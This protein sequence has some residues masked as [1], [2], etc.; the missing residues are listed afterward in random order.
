M[1][2]WRMESMGRRR[3]EQMGWRRFQALGWRMGSSI[4]WRFRWWMGQK[5]NMW[6]KW[7]NIY[8]NKIQMKLQ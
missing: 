4:W 5:M 1:V 7:N 2:G 3:L 6:S 8:T